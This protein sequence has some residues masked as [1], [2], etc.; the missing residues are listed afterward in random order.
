MEQSKLNYIVGGSVLLIA[1][2]VVFMGGNPDPSGPSTVRY[3]EVDK[4]RKQE[5]TKSKLQR[6]KVHVE[7]Y[8]QAPQINE[9]FQG[10]SNHQE[11]GLRLEA[12]VGAAAKDIAESELKGMAVES[13]ENK[14]N[15][16]LLNEQKTAQMNV[17]QRKQFAE[18]YK[19][20]ALSMGYEVELNEKLE[21]IKVQKIEPEQPAIKSNPVIDVD[22]M[23]GDEEY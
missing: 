13:L 7:N 21:V 5:Q 11:E 8:Q 23:E 16:R 10:A 3:G 6:E 4:I 1:T 9:G 14:I 2:A 22:S 15:Q 20:K 19:K 17:L 18:E 12:S